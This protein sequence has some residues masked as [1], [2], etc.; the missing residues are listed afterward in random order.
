MGFLTNANDKLPGE[1]VKNFVARHRIVQVKRPATIDSIQY[2]QMD[3]DM[4]TEVHYLGSLR[5]LD[6]EFILNLQWV[7]LDSKGH[8]VQLPDE[9]V[10]AIV[11]A[12]ERVMKQARSQRAL[13]A[14]KTKIA[15][16][17]NYVP[18]EK[19]DD[20]D[21]ESEDFKFEIEELV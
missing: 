16:N 14:Y 15:N 19:L 6:G 7:D 17:P 5:R 13:N 21:I 18:F 3:M 20:D 10:K 11:R 12:Y 1:T 4:T 2:P 9:V 8:R